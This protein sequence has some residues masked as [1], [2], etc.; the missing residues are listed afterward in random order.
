[1]PL[2]HVN[3]AFAPT[4][5]VVRLLE[6]AFKSQGVS[7]VTRTC[8]L[9]TRVDITHT[10]QRCSRL[11]ACGS[12]ARPEL[13][14]AEGSARCQKLAPFLFLAMSVSRP[15]SRRY[16]LRPIPLS[17]APT[18]GSRS[19]YS[20]RSGDFGHDGRR[21]AS[22]ASISPGALLSLA[23]S[24]NSSEDPPGPTVGQLMPMSGSR[25]CTSCS[26]SGLYPVEH[27]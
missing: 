26:R 10:R 16:R 9:V 15:G 23:D 12:L 27:R 4:L 5:A 11:S 1:M 21:S 6:L 22:R 14:A 25:G 13:Q 3:G 2:P 17:R 24:S 8:A 20:Q 19:R 7:H 18:C